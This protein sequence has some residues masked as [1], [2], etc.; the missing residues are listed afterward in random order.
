MRSDIN[1]RH[2]A[3]ASCLGI[4]AASRRPPPAPRSSPT[5]SRRARRDDIYLLCF[6]LR[7]ASDRGGAQALIA[8]QPWNP[9]DQL[10]PDVA[11]EAR[12]VLAADPGLVWELARQHPTLS[13]AASDRE[14][15]DAAASATRAS[16]APPAKR[17]IK[18][19]K[20]SAA[21]STE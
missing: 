10:I 4:R 13:G 8:R 5:L 17:K 14:A 2:T 9:I 1:T 15:L 21:A 6:V 18:I 19:K 16:A 20:K 11:D 12:F 7:P 3:H